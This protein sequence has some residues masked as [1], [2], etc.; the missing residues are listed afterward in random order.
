MGLA[1]T[2]AAPKAGLANCANTCSSC[3]S[4]SHGTARTKY[5]WGGC[6]TAAL[7]FAGSLFVRSQKEL[8][9]VRAVGPM[10]V[11]RAVAMP[12]DR[13][14]NG[15][16]GIAVAVVPATACE[17]ERSPDSVAILVEMTVESPHAMPVR[18]SLAKTRTISQS[19]TAS[20]WA[21]APCTRSDR[22]GSASG[23]RAV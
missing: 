2:T 3:P 6:L 17:P 11:L 12:Q 20:T 10:Q 1:C 23:A 19:R 21:C 18:R 8:E 13:A 5:R 4:R 9:R 22:A 15:T 14:R 16:H 7:G